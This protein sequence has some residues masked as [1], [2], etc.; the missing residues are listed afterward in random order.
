MSILAIDT[1]MAACSAAWVAADGGLLARRMEPMT[2]GH[3]EALFP[4]IRDVMAEAGHG[5][6][7]LASIAVTIGPGSF[8]GVRAGLAAA[9]GIAL[10]AGRPI[11]AAT[12]LEVMAAGARRKL[13][14]SGFAVA[15]DA[16]R[17]ALYLQCFTA[18]GHAL[19]PP[20]LS[21]LADAPDAI[22]A[23]IGVI[24]GSGAQ[25]VAGSLAE[26]GRDIR[27]F[28]PDLLPDAADL[29]LLAL[30]RTPDDTPPK[31]LYLRPPDAKPQSGK[32]LERV[33]D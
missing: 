7:D 14:P 2:R 17:D 26:T 4:M 5:F 31:P 11:I 27:S 16:R 22:P 23:N 12:S 30:I 21:S 19:N 3:A 9:R 25:L 28:L 20:A 1:S 33:R 29:A 13:P 6:R 15:V 32:S 8:T 10:A 18:E 24:A